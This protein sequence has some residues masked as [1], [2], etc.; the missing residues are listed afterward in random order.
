MTGLQAI[1]GRERMTGRILIARKA[2]WFKRPLRQTMNSVSNHQGAQVT[3]LLKRQRLQAKLKI[4]HP[5]DPSEWEA[6][7]IADHVVNTAEPQGHAQS[8][9]TPRSLGFQ[10][11]Q[12][13][14]R[15]C[16]DCNDE[17]QRKA[18][19]ETVSELGL[20]N[21]SSPITANGRPLPEAERSFFESRMG[22]DFSH[23]RIHTD[24]KAHQLS[25]QINAHAFTIGRHIAF[26]RDAY[27]PGT[28]QGRRLLAHELTHVLQQSQVSSDLV[29]QQFQP[30]IARQCAAGTANLPWNQRVTSAQG[31]AAG[32][33]KNRC[34]AELIRAALGTTITVHES[35]NSSAT[36]DDAI[37]AGHYQERGAG[38]DVNYD[39]NLNAK[40]GNANQY[41]QAEFRTSGSGTANLKVYIVLGPRSLHTI[42]EAHTRMANQHEQDHA[43]DYIQQAA[44]GT[45]RAATAGDEL[46]I[47]V[48]GLTGF[49]LD[50]VQVDTNNCSFSA[51]DDF[52]G[53]FNNFGGASTAQQNS[54]FTAIRNFYTNQITGNTNNTLKF[55]VWF[56][57]T[58]NNRPANDALVRRINALNGLGLTRGTDPLE[59]ICPP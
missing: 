33:A 20:T 17:L 6:D 24:T 25:Q 10:H 35:T 46:R 7:R 15:L 11:S 26:N 28:A 43:N 23:V 49:M 22:A 2:A 38:M 36:I 45:P 41:G 1:L 48:R 3:Q 18:R 4:S 51:S 42:G 30:H 8:G 39:A 5:N 9:D 54:A 29:G 52:S 55:K 58:M 50:L 40:T 47:Y 34:F 13:I 31:M 27:R 37:K 57:S 53:V 44:N 14:Q 59:H 21:A 19:S 56:Q 16:V 12:N 32:Q